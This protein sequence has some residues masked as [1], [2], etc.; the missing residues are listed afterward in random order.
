M[1]KIEMGPKAEVVDLEF[2]PKAEA[3]DNA[4][5]KDPKAGKR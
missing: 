4:N 5:D 3:E 2:G 1:P